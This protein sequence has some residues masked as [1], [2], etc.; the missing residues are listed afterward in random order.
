MDRGAQWAT[1]HRV[2][3]VGHKWSNLA[4]MQICV[5]GFPWGSVVKKLSANAE[6]TEDLGSIPGS[7]NSLEEEMATHPSIPAWEIPWTEE[8]GRL[9]SKRPQKSQT[10][11]E[12]LSKH[13]IFSTFLLPGISTLPWRIF[14][15][16]LMNHLYCAKHFNNWQ[17]SQIP[18]NPALSVLSFSHFRLFKSSKTVTSCQ[19]LWPWV[20]TE[21]W[22]C[23][24][25]KGTPF[26]SFDKGL[27][28]LLHLFWASYWEANRRN[29]FTREMRAARSVLRFSWTHRLFLS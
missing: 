26:C 23:E 17:V 22:P 5:S 29:F 25:A 18:R 8:L 11:L 27:L 21:G 12:Q 10:Q 3:R 9:Q 20:H 14:L 24:A 28:H 7:R 15:W 6:D 19:S 1:V 4:R 2:T 16:I 13:S